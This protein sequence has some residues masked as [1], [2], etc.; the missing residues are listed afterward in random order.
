LKQFE[1][2]FHSRRLHVEVTTRTKRRTWGAGPRSSVGGL[3]SVGCLPDLLGRNA[4]LVGIRKPRQ[5]GVCP[6]EDREELFVGAA[7]VERPQLTREA[8]RINCS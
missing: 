1:R 8:E 7:L 5:P 3:C 4:L 6:T 2:G